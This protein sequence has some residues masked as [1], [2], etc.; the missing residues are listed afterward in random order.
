MLERVQLVCGD[1]GTLGEEYAG[2]YRALRE[3]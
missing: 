2:A 1:D 3:G